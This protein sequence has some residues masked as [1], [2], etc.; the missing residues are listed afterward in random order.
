VRLCV[1]DMRRGRS[2][3]VKEREWETSRKT[4][5]KRLT[6]KERKRK[7]KRQTDRD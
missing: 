2:E 5:R 6:Y 4:D 7:N 3:E 1:T